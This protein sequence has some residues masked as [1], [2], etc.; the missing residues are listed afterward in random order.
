MD[1]G[2]TRDFL[3]R[4]PGRRAACRRARPQTRHHSAH[5]DADSRMARS[6]LRG[7]TR[8]ASQIVVRRNFQGVVT[9]LIPSRIYT[10]LL[11]P[12]TE[13][14]VGNLGLRREAVDTRALGGDFRTEREFKERG[15]RASAGA[16]RASLRARELDSYT[17]RE[18]NTHPLPQFR[19]LEGQ[20]S[21]LHR[22]I[23]APHS[24][25]MP[26]SKRPANRRDPTPCR[27]ALPPE[28]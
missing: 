5:L 19:H 27:S 3:N 16:G 26:I 8:S 25:T 11:D 10:G 7:A 2:R 6:R 1:G 24:G 23:Q 15:G 13:D 28:S 9:E 22:R 18:F 17:V 20:R 4:T 12:M 21:G 14:D